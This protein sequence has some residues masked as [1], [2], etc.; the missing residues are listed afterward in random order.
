SYP[1]WTMHRSWL[2]GGSPPLRIA[3]EQALQP[4][5]A[6]HTRLALLHAPVN[7]APLATTCPTVV[8]IHDLAVFLFPE[9][10]RPARRLYQQTLTRAS[11]RRAAAVIAVSASTRDDVLTL[12]GLETERVAVIHNG[13]GDEMRPCADSAALAAFRRRHGLPERL[14]LYVGTLEP[15]K[16]LVTLIEAYA[17]VCQRAGGD[18]ALVLAGGKGWYYDA[19]YA[20]VERLGL[21]QRVIL[22]GFVPQAELALW[23]NSATLFVYPSL[24][25]GFGLPP[26]EAMAC[27]TPVIVA[28]TSSL[29]EVVGDAGLCCDPRRPDELAEA[30]VALLEDPARRATLAAQG[31]ARAAAFS[32]GATAG[33]TARL[34]HQVLK[35]AHAHP[36]A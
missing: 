19:I 16:N 4:W 36:T 14:I 21:R 22:P 8:T 15:R 35:D 1:G 9:L 11:V 27:G 30:M 28:R 26:L 5:A 17:Q 18:H 23:Y 13:V 12:L 20:A 10:F 6:R 31:V 29:P 7:V 32:W 33:A 25:E 34:Y 2:G 24:Y 3:W